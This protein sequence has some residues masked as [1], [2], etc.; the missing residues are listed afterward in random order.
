MCSENLKAKNCRNGVVIATLSTVLLIG[1][2][3]KQEEPRTTPAASGDH[4]AAQS[5]DSSEPKKPSAALSVTESLVAPIALYPDPLLAEVL[6]A[7]T[8]PREIEQAARLLEAGANS[9]AAGD[10]VLDA[11]IV[12]LERLPQVIVMLREHPQWTTAL[13]NAFLASPETLLQAIQTLRQRA[14]RSSY[15]KDSAAQKV[16]QKAVPAAPETSASSIPTATRDRI[17]ILPAETEKIQVPLYDPE[18]VFS[19][20]LAVPPMSSGNQTAAQ[21][22]PSEDANG[23][24]VGDYYPAYYPA[25]SEPSESGSTYLAFGADT[26]V[27]GVLTWGNIEWNGGGYAVSHPYGKLTDCNGADDCW[28]R[29][30]DNAY[31]YAHETT[32]DIANQGDEQAWANIPQPT[33]GSPWQHDPRHRR[34]LRY[35]EDAA[36]RLGTLGPPSFAG[37]R[38]SVLALPLRERGFDVALIA[39]EVEEEGG[40]VKRYAEIARHSVFSGIALAKEQNNAE[41]TRGREN[42]NRKKADLLKQTDRPA[43]E[44]RR[45]ISK[46]LLPQ[47]MQIEAMR[48]LRIWQQRREAALPSA[49][50]AVYD[51]GELIARFSRRGAES[52][53]K[54]AIFDAR[55]T[56]KL[57]AKREQEDAD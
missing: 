50:E 45:G 22:L 14:I 2:C 19:A 3:N 51:K 47:G 39:E 37:Q 23:G 57:P 55:G 29:S 18:T 5:A 16:L 44:T 25:S 33:S 49:F 38:L 4:A 56:A 28:L 40:V 42:R 15:L 35:S 13:G 8:Y 34:G 20:S 48:A 10:N 30:S 1:A 24:T 7:A 43:G 12:R 32:A 52:R 21:Q 41:T 9:T 6:I 53:A 11:S 36:K 17:I 46:P 27:K 31:R 54:Q 26:A